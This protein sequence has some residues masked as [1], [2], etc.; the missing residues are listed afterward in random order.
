MS[1]SDENPM[2]EVDVEMAETAKPGAEV[3]AVTGT[4]QRPPMERKMSRSESFMNTIEGSVE[5][6]KQTKSKFIRH[7][8]EEL[9]YTAWVSNYVFGSFVG[10]LPL[11]E[12]HYLTVPRLV[13]FG[14]LAY[15]IYVGLFLGTVSTS[16]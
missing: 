6:V 9:T 1:K 16:C 13:F 5:S 3:I 8:E 14:V 11:P 4:S 2:K 12:L 10:N 15:C 7:E